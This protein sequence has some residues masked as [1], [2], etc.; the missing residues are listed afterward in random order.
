MVVP[1]LKRTS[2]FQHPTARY[3]PALEN[4]IELMESL[5]GSATSISFGSAVVFAAAPKKDIEKEVLTREQQNQ[6]KILSANCA[7]VHVVSG[8]SHKSSG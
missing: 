5:G 8:Q 4:D 1:K 2:L 6:Q 3:S 7:Q